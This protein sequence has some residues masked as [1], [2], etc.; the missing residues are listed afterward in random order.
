[1]ESGSSKPTSFTPKTNRMTSS[2]VDSWRRLEAAL[3]TLGLQGVGL[4]PGASDNDIDAFQTHL[5][6]TLPPEVR[7]WFAGHDGQTASTAGLAAGFHF[8]SLREAQK[9]MQDWAQVR[10]KLGHGVKD[11][12]RACSSTPPKAIQ[13]KYSCPA[14]LPLLRDNEGNCVGVDLEPGSA[15][16][17]GQ[18]INFGRDE[19]DKYVLFP[20][21]SALLDWLATELESGRIA[22]D[23]EDRVVRH[24]AGRLVSA[25][26][27][28]LG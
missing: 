21:A 23:E 17:V 8:L 24:T 12:D 2:V 14:W 11:L 18:I 10:T 5:G 25:I 19:D 20:N 27:V 13:R 16:S 3:P 6:L 22:Y 9:I 15:G 1:M 26:T 7:E 28:N 4:A